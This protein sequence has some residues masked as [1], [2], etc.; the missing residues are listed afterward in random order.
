MKTLLVTGATSGIGLAVVEAALKQS[1][2]VV[3]C[4]RNVA[5][6]SG[7]K[8]DNLTVLQFD[9]TDY[10]ACQTALRDIHPDI[11][12]LNAGVCEYLDVDTFDAKMFKRNFD[13]NVFGVM[14][15][16]EALLPNLTAGAQLVFVESLARLL[17]FTKA[18][19]Y[20]SSKAALYYAANS[21]RTDLPDI[22]IQ[23][24]SPGFVDTPLTKRNTFE[25]PMM[26]STEQA[27]SEILKGI[28]TRKRHISFPRGFSL[29]LKLLSLLPINIQ[30]RIC[31]KLS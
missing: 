11:A 20:G 1:Y 6:L 7:F 19:G 13:V 2:H 28:A 21:L 23:T 24:V 4:G 12:V 3:A 26:V 8:S 17:P 16:V 15:V 5:A 22:V 31:R 9:V 10:D 14:N 29:I 25:M 30:T 18:S 27:A